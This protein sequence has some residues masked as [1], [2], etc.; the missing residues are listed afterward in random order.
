MNELQICHSETIQQRSKETLPEFIKR[1][2]EA[3]NQLSHLEEKEAININKDR[4]FPF[5]LQRLSL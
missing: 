5:S 1:F 4:K 3:V 2:Q